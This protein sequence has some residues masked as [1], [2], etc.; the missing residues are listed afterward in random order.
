LTAPAP[1]FLRQREA[2]LQAWF[3]QQIPAL[4]R[5]AQR[6]GL[7]SVSGDASFRRYF[8]AELDAGPCILVDAPPPQE[9]CRPFVEVA[10]WL[11]GGG[12]NVPAL[13]ACNLAA[14]FMC[15]SDFGDE[16]L[17]RRLAAARDDAEVR[18]SATALY[19]AAFAELLKIQAT[20]ARA[21]PSYDTALLRR[22]L[23]LF[24]EWFCQGLLQLN[25]SA[26]ELLMIEQVFEQ[27]IARALAQPQV[28]VHRDYHSRNL[29]YL[30]PDLGV[31][32]FQD[33]VRGPFTYD[34]VSLLRDCYIEWPP[35]QVQRWLFDYAAMA[36]AAGLPAPPDSGL[37]QDFDWM[38]MQRH[39]KV[40]GIFARLWLRDGKRGYLG[41]LP[42]TLRYLSSAA[43]GYGEFAA[44]SQ[45][46][47]ERVEPA[48]PPLLCSLG[49][50]EAK[51]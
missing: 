50:S 5:G 18:P 40:L 36:R 23:L 25:L 1:D 21:L 27:L 17:W 2:A 12:V 16:L 47:S 51:S 48:L 34:L 38:G 11:R 15:L 44:F 45:W 20:E 26:Q 7:A 29:M 46:L 10:K 41:D 35:E 8:R 43:R 31:I 14:G 42:L 22:E 32:D 37:Q 4:G 39:L 49:V 6:Q 30:G 3:S 13:Y 24:N 9:D 28:F 33:A 19:H